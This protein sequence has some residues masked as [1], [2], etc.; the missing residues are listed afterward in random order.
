MQQTSLLAY[1]ELDDTK[2][3]ARQR[4]VKDTIRQIQ[5]ATNR[6]I[7]AHLKWPINTV[8]PRVKELRGLGQVD[9]AKR[10][11]DVGGRKAI[12]WKIAEA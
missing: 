3:A 10:D 1:R 2:L 6:M 7:A 4:I 9:E 5:P 8:T 12:F 11:I